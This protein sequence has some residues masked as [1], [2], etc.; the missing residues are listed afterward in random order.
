MPKY[1]KDWRKEDNYLVREFVFENF[2]QAVDFVN[3]IV[4]LAE[5]Q[6]HH[7]DIEIFSFKK[8]KVKLTTHDEGYEITQK[9]IALAEQINNINI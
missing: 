7:P 9:D 5:E 1:P 2:I 6:G 3:K 4:P 8:V